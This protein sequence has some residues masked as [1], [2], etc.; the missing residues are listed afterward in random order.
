MGNDKNENNSRLM[1]QGKGLAAVSVCLIILALLLI[2]VLADQSF[3][4]QGED[5][6]EIK[7]SLEGGSYLILAPNEREKE[8]SD[9]EIWGL[10]KDG[11]ARQGIVP[12]KSGFLCWTVLHL[13]WNE[14]KAEEAE[15][16]EQLQLSQETAETI[17][18]VFNDF[19][20]EKSISVPHRLNIDISLWSGKIYLSGLC[21][22]YDYNLVDEY[23]FLGE[24]EEE[25]L[26][27][28]LL[29]VFPDTEKAAADVYVM[30]DKCTVAVYAP[31]VGK[32]HEGTDFPY[33]DDNWCFGDEPMYGFGWS[34]LSKNGFVIGYIDANGVKA[35]NDY[36]EF[37]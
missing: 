26:K 17:M 22:D 3:V 4:P 32:L 14:E 31:N 18:T 23:Y 1:R 30:N 36:G 19:L 2:A 37:F 5:W 24:E 10:I 21:L 13:K 12:I 34:E 25:E 9:N 7:T 27:A 29:E 35:V 6:K 28:R 20:S 15:R 33:I 11:M 16:A 8:H